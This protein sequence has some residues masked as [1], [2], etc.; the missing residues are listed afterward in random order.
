MKRLLSLL[1]ALTLIMLCTAPAA[2]GQRRV[3]PVEP[4]PGTQG[5]PQ[6][7]KVDPRANLAERK[8]AQ[9]NVV[10]VDT[11]TGE[12]WVDSTAVTPK[13]KMLYPLFQ[14]VEV[15]VN[16]FDLAMRAFGENYGLFDVW[17]QL[18]I[19]NRYMPFVAFGLGS[20]DETPDGQNYT[21]KSKT[22]P[23]FKLGFN[24]NIFYNNSP[25]YQF[26]LGARYGFSNFKFE[27]SDITIDEGYW[28]SPTMT[29]IP[30]QSSTVGYV[31]LTAGVKV[32]I[33]GPLSMGWTISYHSIL[34]ESK[35]KM[36]KPMY[37]PGFGKRGGTFGAA[38][39]IIYTLPLNK[40]GPDKVNTGD[41]ES[42]DT[43]S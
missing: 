43:N 11:V 41:E 25:D 42:D 21:Y 18:N 5:A 30:S 6:P 40:K 16:V 15:G 3:T 23:Y 36:G 39:S 26:T 2:M 34:H 29:S 9:G 37:I 24:Y 28:G 7:V 32:K 31:E 12:E 22:A 4:R 20:C 35:P 33:V 17:A 38:F 10:L 19:H 27:V 14:S 1:L 8:D 13:K